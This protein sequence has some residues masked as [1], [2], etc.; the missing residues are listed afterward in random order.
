MQKNGVGA[1][2]HQTRRASAFAQASGLEANSPVGGRI[3]KILVG[4]GLILLAGATI[5][6]YSQSLKLLGSEDSERNL[7]TPFQRTVK[8]VRIG[9]A[10][11]LEGRTDDAIAIF[12]K[13][14]T[15]TPEYLPAYIG[16]GHALEQA[17]RYNEA[18]KTYKLVLKKD[19]LHLD[20]R[21]QIAEIH[22][23]RG[24]WAEA[25]QEY[26]QIMEIDPLSL[27]ALAALTTI[28]RQADP[29]NQMRSTT[30]I[31]RQLT[32]AGGL[33]SMPPSAR[34]DKAP[35]P[36]IASQTQLLPA[37][38]DLFA[39]TVGLE[40]AAK[41]ALRSHYKEIG[42]QLVNRKRHVEAIDALKSARQLNPDD[43]DLYYLLAS[44]H[45]GLGNYREAYRY[46]SMC[47][48]SQ[49]AG[50]CKSGMENARRESTRL[51]KKRGSTPTFEEPSDSIEEN[52]IG[53]PNRTSTN[54][55]R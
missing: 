39:D 11:M 44:A 23:A 41:Q 38:P 3:R 5:G 9:E 17:Q 16:L 1:T 47:Q 55:L 14:K 40:R 53:L 37:P 51:A 28:E 22:R 33:S 20:A 32:I 24:E 31:T 7:E 46:Y 48:T 50:S 43:L 35:Q 27:Q 29:R 13:A 8:Q 52:E 25:Y 15:L 18:L 2:E 21:Y 36:P 6:Y 30:P 49:Y 54:S 26:K 42:M 19:P 34:W 10:A 45:Y 12:D 4:F